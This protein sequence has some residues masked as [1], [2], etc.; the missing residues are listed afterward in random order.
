MNAR[1]P[2]GRIL[3]CPVNVDDNGVYTATFK[4]D[5]VG[6][7]KINVTYEG[8]DIQES[9][10]ICFVFDPHAVKVTRP[11]SICH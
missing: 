4:P 5:E 6:E 2:T 9:P 8:E 1:S 11:L 10:F 3:P 7:W